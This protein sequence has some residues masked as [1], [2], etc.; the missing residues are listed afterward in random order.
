VHVALEEAGVT[1]SGNAECFVSGKV[2][3]KDDILED[4]DV[5]SIVTPKQA[6]TN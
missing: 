1:L 5:L 2:A 3:E 6:G 4:K